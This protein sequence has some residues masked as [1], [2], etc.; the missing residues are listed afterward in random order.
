M[1]LKN[2]QLE[3]SLQLFEVIKTYGIAYLLGEVRSGK[4]GTALNVAKLLGVKN[5]LIIT[6]KK[7][8]SDIEKQYQDFGFTFN[9]WVINYES[10]HKIDNDFDFVIIDEAHSI[11]A[12]PKQSLRTKL[13]KE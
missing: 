1:E 10:L 3:K 6:K 4:T 7:A 2:N 13:I 12:Y 11:S 9:L 8:I 5:T